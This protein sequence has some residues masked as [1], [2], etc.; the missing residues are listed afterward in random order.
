MDSGKAFWFLRAVVHVLPGGHRRGLAERLRNMR[1]QLAPRDGKQ[2]VGGSRV[3]R[4]RRC[5]ASKL[6]LGG[7]MLQGGWQPNWN[8]VSQV[9]SGAV[10][11]PRG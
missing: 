4:L 10:A 6:R 7:I 9:V 8:L 3:R 2:D 11:M 5:S 1:R